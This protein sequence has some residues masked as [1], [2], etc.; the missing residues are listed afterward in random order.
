MSP[1]IKKA[2]DKIEHAVAKATAING[3]F[4]SPSISL[5]K[6]GGA[7]RGIGEKFNVSPATGTSSF[8]VPIL[9]SSGRSGFGPELSIT[10]DS[11]AGNGPLGFGWSL[12]LPS[13]TRK[14]D[15][16]LPLYRD[17]VES[18]VY[19][20]TGAE[21]LIPVYQTDENGDPVRDNNGIPVHEEA[22]RDGYKVRFYRPRTE[23]LF[24]RIER[25]TGTGGD[26]HWRSISK[27]NIL[28]VYGRD[29]TSR[30]AD[31][32]LPGHIFSWLICESYDDRGNAILYEYKAEN[33]E[34]IDPALAS[35]RNRSRDANRYLKRVHYGNRE[36]LLLDTG[37]PDFR[38]PHTGVVDFS[39]AGWMFEVVFDYGEGHYRTLPD[40]TG[41]EIDRH[42]FVLA[43]RDAGG[44]W[45]CR[46]DQFSAC[47]AGFEIRTHRRCQRVLLFHSFQ[48]LG[49][50]PQ[51]VSSVELN[52]DDF[53][54]TQ[55]F[56]T[57]EELGHKGSTRMASFVRSI[58]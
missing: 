43:S 19:I 9:V 45:P 20:L 55:P 34:G 52:Y 37:V 51:L 25:W 3:T 13:I 39:A 6:G 2:G 5:P 46:P 40:E 33:D 49:D 58:T 12:A 11:G 50:E 41:L 38:Q 4:S 31:P 32:A 1:E 30:I 54:Y 56:T 35:E 17:G 21:D 42:V 10:Y 57:G 29:T 22:T 27:D 8:T 15:K 7:I 23:G 26:V 48:E 16:G 36:P 24:A 14:T 18:D 28:T 47:R 53:D 44:I